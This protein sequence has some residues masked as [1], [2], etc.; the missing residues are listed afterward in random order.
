KTKEA[1]ATAAEYNWEP[2]QGVVLRLEDADVVPQVVQRGNVAEA[3]IQY[4]LLGTGAGTEVTETR[5][6]RRGAEVVG[7][8]SQKSYTRND[9]TWVS[10]QQFKIAP[11][12]APGTYTLVQTVQSATQAINANTEFIVQ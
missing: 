4:A 1:A 10:S 6:L 8:L 11:N 9:G 12:L 3:T 5:V 2:Q 7:T